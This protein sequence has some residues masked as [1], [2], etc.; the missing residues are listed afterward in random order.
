[1]ESL[2][3]LWL[4]KKS[5]ER[6]HENFL[7]DDGNVGVGGDDENEISVFLSVRR[8]RRSPIFDAAEASE[9]ETR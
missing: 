1:V 5:F 6:K 2:R 4:L 8:F 9:C 7:L 3:H